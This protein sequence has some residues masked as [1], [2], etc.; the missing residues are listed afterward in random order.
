MSLLTKD[1]ILSMAARPF[2]FICHKFQYRDDKNRAKCKDL[3]K[4]GSLKIEHQD[5]TTVTYRRAS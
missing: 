1:Q 3:L 2:G 4:Q 5:K